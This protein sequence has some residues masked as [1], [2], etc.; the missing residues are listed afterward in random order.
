MLINLTR[1]FLFGT[2]LM[3]D[4][5]EPF[6]ESLVYLLLVIL[7]VVDLFIDPDLE[8]EVV[9]FTWLEGR[10][11]YESNAVDEFCSVNAFSEA[12]QDQFKP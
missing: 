11:I 7:L 5:V 2:V 4:L 12:Y 9:L 10:F 6:F 8:T 1:D 3:E